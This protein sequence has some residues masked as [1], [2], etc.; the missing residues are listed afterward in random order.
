MAVVEGQKVR[1]IV[2]GVSRGLSVGIIFSSLAAFGWVAAG[3]VKAADTLTEVQWAPFVGAVILQFIMML[4]LMLLWERLLTILWGSQRRIDVK[5]IRPGIYTAYSRSWLA[6]YIPGRVWALGGR[7]LLA[8]KVGVP[9]EAVARSMALLLVAR[10]HS[11]AGLAA[12]ILGLL[13]FTISVPAAQRLLAS[14]RKASSQK[15]LWSKARQRA[16]RFL[17]GPTPFSLKNSLWAVSIYGI[18]SSL[19]LVFIALI[20]ES[21]VDL[22]LTQTFIIAG[23]WGLSVTLGWLS[24][25]PVGLGVRDVLAS[26]LFAQVLDAPT[27]SLIVAASR[28]VMIAIDLAFVGAVELLALGLTSRQT[29][30]QTSA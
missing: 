28:I 1:G 21:F 2:R 9:A 12:F 14:D 19:Q 24:F 10:A 30:P 15:S 20:A 27:A 29:Q 13:A 8:S 3:A 22:T 7:V 18:Y 17:I 16:Q 11:L 5:P 23:A 4:F 6:R 26:V 25:L